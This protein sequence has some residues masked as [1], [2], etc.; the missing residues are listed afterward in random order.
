MP[1]SRTAVFQVLHEICD[2][3][4]DF[5]PSLEEIQEA[6]MKFQV[7]GDECREG[8]VLTERGRLPVGEV[9]RGHVSVGL[10]SGVGKWGRA[11]GFWPA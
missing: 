10:N 9:L 11:P 6:L 8:V 1:T 4:S 3:M 7:P 2:L 5:S